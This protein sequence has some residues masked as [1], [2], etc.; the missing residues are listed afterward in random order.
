MQLQTRNEQI[1]AKENKLCDRVRKGQYIWGKNRQTQR[2][3]NQ[4]E[5]DKM[6]APGWVLMKWMQRA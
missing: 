1:L 4:H 5:N 3:E 6:D 2:K